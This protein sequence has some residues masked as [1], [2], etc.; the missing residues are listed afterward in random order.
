MVLGYN[1]VN[2]N[3]KFIVIHESFQAR[4]TNPAIRISYKTLSNN[5]RININNR[6]PKINNNHKKKKKKKKN[7]FSPENVHSCN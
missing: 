7:L 2:K 6:E 1:P 4:K 3:D 5:A